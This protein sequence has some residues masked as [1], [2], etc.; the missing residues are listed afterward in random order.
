MRKAIII[1]LG[2]LLALGC[3]KDVRK[4]TP[5]DGF[6]IYL[7]AITQKSIETRAPYELTTP[8]ETEGGIL[9]SEVWASSTDGAYLDKG[10]NGKNNGSAVAIHSY[11]DFNSGEPQLLNTAV[12]PQSG[13]PVHF[14]G[15][16][17][18]GNWNVSDDGTKASYTF[19][20]SQDVMFAAKITGTYADP[21]A[22]DLIFDVPVLRFLHLLTWIK[23]KMIAEDEDTAKA[24]GKIKEMKITSQNNVAIALDKDYSFDNCVTFSSDNGGLIPLHKKGSNDVFPDTGGYQLQYY[25]QSDAPAEVAYVLCSPVIADDIEIENGTEVTVPEYAIHIETERRKISLP[26]DLRISESRYFTG[27]TRSRC[28]TINLIFKMGN[29]IVVSAE[30]EDWILGGRGSVDIVE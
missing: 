21:N 29:A 5:E 23:V 19:D 8:D 10:W 13:T 2:G 18:Q 24:W 12:Y 6:P 30:V 16:H 28:F 15:L 7:S 27:S 1:V 22:E 3:Q 25:P 20:G 17:P 26:I 9:H 4:D 11:A 14:V